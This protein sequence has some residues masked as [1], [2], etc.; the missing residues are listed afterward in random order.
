ML[1]LRSRCLKMPR[2]VGAATQCRVYSMRCS[3]RSI[4]HSGEAETGLDERKA[5]RQQ[6]SRS[7]Q[8]GSQVM[9]PDCEPHPHNW[10][11]TQTG[12][13]QL[14]SNSSTCLPNTAEYSGCSPTLSRL[15]PP[16]ST[17]IS[18]SPSANCGTAK[19]QRGTKGVEVPSR[20]CACRHTR[21]G[22]SRHTSPTHPDGGWRECPVHTLPA[23]QELDCAKLDPQARAVRLED[24]ATSGA[25]TAVKPP[26]QAR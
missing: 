3:L 17:A 21:S 15:L 2:L 4:P 16:S 13:Q 10:D 22:A 18:W 1:H 6:L 8:Q 14:V 24:G 26:L 20:L 7:K 9:F 12:K 11:Q 19:Q 5:C 25:R 23:Q